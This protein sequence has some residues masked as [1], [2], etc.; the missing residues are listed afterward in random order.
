MPR[1]RRVNSVKLELIKK[2]R[3]AAL[4]AVQIF[5]NPNITF[6]AEAFTRLPS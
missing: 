6:K 2:S 5:N 1:N 4:S 3:E